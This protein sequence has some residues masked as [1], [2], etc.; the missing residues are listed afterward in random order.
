MAPE[1]DQSEQLALALRQKAGGFRVLG[2]FPGAGN[3]TP[4][5]IAAEVNKCLDRIEAGDV[6]PLNH[7]DEGD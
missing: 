3:P 2:I 4:E 7:F 1:E 6:E 5:E